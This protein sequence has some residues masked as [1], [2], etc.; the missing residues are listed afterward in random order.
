MVDWMGGGRLRTGETKGKATF[1]KNR[2]NSSICFV[3]WMYCADGDQMERYLQQVEMV[4]AVR[5]PVFWP[6]GQRLECEQG[7][8]LQ[9][10]LLSPEALSQRPGE[11][12]YLITQ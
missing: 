4:P 9:Y 5:M 7:K 6:S 10:R 3:L 8:I 12:C 2:V 11:S 1:E